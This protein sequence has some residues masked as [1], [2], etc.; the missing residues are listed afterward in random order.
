MD[1][2]YPSNIRF[3][4]ERLIIVPCCG[5]G[6]SLQNSPTCILFTSPLHIDPGSVTLNFSQGK[7]YIFLQDCRGSKINPTSTKMDCTAENRLLELVFYQLQD[8][9]NSDSIDKEEIIWYYRHLYI[10]YKT[11]KITLT[12]SVP[13]MYNSE[14]GSL[15]EINHSI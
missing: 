5:T 11:V 7:Y 14:K 2:G 8:I 1:E 9:N 4:Q 10:P 13:Y 15:G 12:I 6:Q 3:Y